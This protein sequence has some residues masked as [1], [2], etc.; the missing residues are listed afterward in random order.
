MLAIQKRARRTPDQDELDQ[1]VGYTEL[2]PSNLHNLEESFAAQ[3]QQQR[4]RPRFAAYNGPVSLCQSERSPFAIVESLDEQAETI[5]SPLLLNSASYDAWQL[6]LKQHPRGVGRVFLATRNQL[7]LHWKIFSKS[8]RELIFSVTVGSLSQP[9]P[10]T[11]AALAS[12]SGTAGSE[13]K[14]SLRRR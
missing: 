13:P 1:L 5:R 10:N 14:H 8:G 6:I 9:R 7:E 2:N 11:C 4:A 3:S 12:A